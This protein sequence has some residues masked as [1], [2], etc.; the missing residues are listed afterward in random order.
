MTERVRNAV[1]FYKVFKK[2][3]VPRL[4]TACRIQG[5]F[6]AQGWSTW[7][8]SY[9]E[10]MA[11]AIAHGADRLDEETLDNMRAWIGECLLISAEHYEL[12]K[13]AARPNP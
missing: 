3:I 8:E 11:I 10:V 1:A 9:E 2:H 12:R 6:V 13:P 4:K 5:Y 7:V